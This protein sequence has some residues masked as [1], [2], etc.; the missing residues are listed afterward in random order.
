VTSPAGRRFRVRVALLGL[1]PLLAL[2]ALARFRPPDGHEH[3]TLAQFFGR[4][5][6]TIVHFP[7]ALLALVLVLEIAGATRRW[8]RVRDSAGSILALATLGAFAA[9]FLGWLL[10]WSGGSRGP[11]VTLHLW[12]GVWLCFA[13][14]VCCS[15]RRHAPA[16]PGFLYGV[17]LTATVGLMVWTSHL[18]GQLSHGESYLTQY[19]PARARAWIGLPAFAPHGG[20]SAGGARAGGTLSFY[21]A[22]IAPI[23]DDHCVVCHDANKQKGKL[24]LDSYDW[25]MRGG[26]DGLVIKPGDPKGSDLF[27]RITLPPDDDDFMPSDGKPALKPYDVMLIEHWIATGASATLADNFA[28]VVAEAPAVPPAAP[29]D[30]P[31][32]TKLGAL[33]ASLGVRLVPRSQMPTDGIILRTVSAPGRCDDAALVQLE[34]VGALI[35]EAELART[36]VTDA[37]LKTLAGFHNLR[38]IDLSYTAI[39]SAN[40]GELTALPHLYKLNLT[41]T[42][43]DASGLAKLR[44]A[45]GLKH[46]YYFQTKAS[47]H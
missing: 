22:S 8:A 19:L 27:R 31:F 17:A 26:E 45:P 3:A 24:R 11:L 28:P 5:H 34:P 16:A 20:A 6:P 4:F 32:L 38:S 40:L 13:C 47:A 33:E 37:G 15:L 2:F 29:D 23:F 36:K 25:I 41:G 18:G 14:V 9:A 44:S 42:A 46:I 39:T 35:V 30:R 43:I 12:S 7:I 10:A 1:P 21:S